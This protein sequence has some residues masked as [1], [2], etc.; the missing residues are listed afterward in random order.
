MAKQL[1]CYYNLNLLGVVSVMTVVISCVQVKP[2]DVIVRV[3][4]T[5]LGNV[6]TQNQTLA[7][8]RELILGEAGTFVNL[9]TLSALC[10]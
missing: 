5:Q 8:L 1:G 6:N 9:G 7:N 3:G 2:G 4:Q 10:A